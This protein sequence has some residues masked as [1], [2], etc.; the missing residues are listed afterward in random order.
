[1]GDTFDPEHTTRSVIGSRFTVGFTNILN[2]EGVPEHVLDTGVTVSR[3]DMGILLVL[4]AVKI[5]LLPEPDVPMPIFALEL[6]QLYVVLATNE[7]PKLR[8]TLVPL[9]I[10]RFDKRVIVGVGFT[11]KVK[12]LLIPLHPLLNGTTMNRELMGT[13]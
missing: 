12:D 8:F 1:M 11:L 10:F 2:T 6:D 3:P 9:H 4:L 7:P 5:R 13:L